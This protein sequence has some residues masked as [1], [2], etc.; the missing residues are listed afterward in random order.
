[1]NDHTQAG[2]FWAALHHRIC[3]R[4]ANPEIRGWLQRHAHLTATTRYG[5]PVMRLVLD[6]APGVWVT[7]GILLR[8]YRA[9]AEGNGKC[10][11]PLLDLA[12]IEVVDSGAGA[13]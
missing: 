7:D 3:D 6:A 12:A 8:H 2:P 13:L 9:A 11:S 10:S 4:V 1:M 5:W